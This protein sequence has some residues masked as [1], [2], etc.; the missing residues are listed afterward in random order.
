MSLDKT[1]GIGY[2]SSLRQAGAY[3]LE[4]TLS[5]GV[6]IQDSGVTNQ[7]E[8]WE[9][10]SRH[11]KHREVCASPQTKRRALYEREEKRFSKVNEPSGNVYENKGPGFSGWR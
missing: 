11:E 5:A 9:R 8:L 3:G 2:C 4:A 6:R 7:G 10:A 1:K